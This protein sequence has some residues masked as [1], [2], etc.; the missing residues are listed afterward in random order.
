MTTLVF[1]YP[2][3]PVSHSI[4][5]SCSSH[6]ARVRMSGSASCTKSD[7][8]PVGLY[9]FRRASAGGYYA[10]TL[11]QFDIIMKPDS[12]GRKI[13]GVTKLRGPYDDLRKCW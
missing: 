7:L 2:G 10:V 12:R 13:P 3:V 6:R 9:S 4:V 5:I 11:E 8:P 1:A